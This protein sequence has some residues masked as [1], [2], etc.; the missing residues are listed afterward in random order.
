VPHANY[1]F[2]WDPLNATWTSIGGQPIRKGPIAGIWSNHERLYKPDELV[3]KMLETGFELEVVEEQTH[4]SFP[5]IHFLVYGIGKPLI[6]KNLLPTSLR[7]SADRFR[8][9]QNQGSVLNPINLGVGVLRYFDRRNDTPAIENQSTF[10][11]ILV[12]A[13]KPWR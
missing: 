5:F 2:W 10:V 1:P 6:E 12:K 13:R 11:N 9:E 8:G 7:T 4:Y 3:Q